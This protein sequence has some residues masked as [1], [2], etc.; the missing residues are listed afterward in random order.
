MESVDKLLVEDR[1]IS[2]LSDSQS[3]YFNQPEVELGEVDYSEFME[4]N[5]RSLR[6]HLGLDEQIILVESNG[7]SLY[8][9]E[10]IL[11]IRSI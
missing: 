4:N 1:W 7:I 5:S 3:S 6:S 8:T 11:E 2:A 10:L 9:H